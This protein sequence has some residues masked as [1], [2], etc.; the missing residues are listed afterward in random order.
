MSDYFSPYDAD[1]P[2]ML[3]CPPRRRRKNITITGSVKM[4]S[5]TKS[6]ALRRWRS[7]NSSLCST[8]HNWL[9]NSLMTVGE[10]TEACKKWHIFESILE[11]KN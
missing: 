4:R 6:L 5:R 7:W 10:V 9:S 11:S 8:L 1:R 2:L 3:K